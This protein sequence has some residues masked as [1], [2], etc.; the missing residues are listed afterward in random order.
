LLVSWQ[1]YVGLKNALAGP[2]KKAG[3]LAWGPADNLIDAHISSEF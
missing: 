1:E 3:T 2:M